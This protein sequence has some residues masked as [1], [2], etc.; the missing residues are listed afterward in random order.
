[1]ND[2]SSLSYKL[3]TLKLEFFN[4]AKYAEVEMDED[5]LHHEI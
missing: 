2:F 5:D 3:I 1:M 4:T